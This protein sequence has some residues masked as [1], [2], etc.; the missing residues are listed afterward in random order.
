MFAGT[1]TLFLALRGRRCIGVHTANRGESERT[2]WAG[3]PSAFSCLSQQKRRGPG[4]CPCCHHLQSHCQMRPQHLGQDRG[5]LSAA[6]ISRAPTAKL[7]SFKH[8]AQPHF[9]N[10]REPR[11][12]PV[13]LCPQTPEL[14]LQG[15]S[16]RRVFQM[17]RPCSGSLLYPLSYRTQ[18]LTFLLSEAQKSLIQQ[19][20][21]SCTQGE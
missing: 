18:R 14:N 16:T 7:T 5:Q 19:T 12:A 11:E 21:Q 10:F 17:P 1:V 20:R 13:F 15:N 6:F 8:S 2:P 9:L 4:D 3:C